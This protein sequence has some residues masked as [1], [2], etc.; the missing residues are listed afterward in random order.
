MAMVDTVRQKVQR[1]LTDELNRVEI[2]RD[3]DFVIRF[4]SV[5]VFV[6]IYPMTDH[7]DSDVAVRVYCPMITDVNL[8]PDLYKWIATEG[9]QF[10][11]G[12]TYI[13]PDDNG[14]TGW[15]Y[16]RITLIGNDLDP[17]ELNGAV[18]RAVST[19]N[20]LDDRLKQMFGGKLFT[21]A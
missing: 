20:D 14:K 16:F 21:E 5:V 3:G 18:F 17:N 7:E 2:D 4:E 13:N 6:K 8:T 11:F 19:A 9:Q 10:H 15:I 12:S 1:I